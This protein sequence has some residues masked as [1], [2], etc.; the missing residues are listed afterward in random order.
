MLGDVL[1]IIKDRLEESGLFGKV[2]PLVVLKTDG[3][4]TCPVHYKGGGQYEPLEY[5]IT[6]GM[7]YFRKLGK[8]ITN[9]VTKQYATTSCP[10]TINETK[11]PFRFVA[12]IPK[13]KAPC[14]DEFTEDYFVERLI[15]EI[16]SLDITGYIN[17]IDTE[18]TSTGHETDSIA[19]K[20]SEGLEIVDM[21]YNWAYIYIDFLFTI[22]IDINCLNPCDYNYG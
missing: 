15:S 19:V 7:G 21:N 12:M 16:G 17:A 8:S 13:D 14:D 11:T 9:D 1:H 20:D 4:K 18:F 5:D 10:S 3:N 6:R 2:Y 22:V